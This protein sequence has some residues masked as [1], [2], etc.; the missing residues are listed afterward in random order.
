MRTLA[1]LW[2]TLAAVLAGCGEG[3]E[4][5]VPTSDPPQ[6]TIGE[7]TWTVEIADSPRERTRGLGGRKQL[8]SDR[9]M[10][11]IFP[12]EQERTF[13]MRDC[14]IPLDIA[15]L[16]A[17]HRVV[18]MHTMAVEPDRAGRVRYRSGRPAQYALE[19]P[20]GELTRA[21]VEVGDRARFAGVSDGS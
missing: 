21:G 3:E 1:L 20:A 7:A 19:V 2:M 9:G 17:D 4:Y 14:Y 11:F 18:R 15:F 10:L 13:V 16:D 5:R 8:A 12:D 6:V